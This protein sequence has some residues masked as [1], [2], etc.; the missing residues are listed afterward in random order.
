M[1]VVKSKLASPFSRIAELDLANGGRLN[2]YKMTMLPTIPR[3]LIIVAII[4]TTCPRFP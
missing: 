4:V 1:R 3:Q 2:T